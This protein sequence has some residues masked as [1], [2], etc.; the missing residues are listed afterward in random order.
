MEDDHDKHSEHRM[1][2]NGFT[3]HVELLEQA[4]KRF[5]NAATAYCDHVETGAHAAC[6]PALCP[7]H[8]GLMDAHKVL[9][10]T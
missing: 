9:I 6:D 4:E 1:D 8:L 5:L 2:T 7:L 10:T 3:N